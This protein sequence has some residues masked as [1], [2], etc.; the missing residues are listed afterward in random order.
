MPLDLTS[1]DC[2]LPVA[3]GV[4]INL[5]TWYVTAQPVYNALGTQNP[6]VA[7]AQAGISAILSVRDPMEVTAPTNPFDLTEAQQCILNN[8]AY[9]NV[10]LPHVPMTQAQFNVQ[11]YNAATVI[12]A[13]TAG[14]S[15]LIHCSSGDRASAAFACFLIAYDNWTNQQ[16]VEYAQDTLVLQ[17]PQFVAYVTNFQKP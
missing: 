6:Y 1:S 2:S 14:R 16:A 5:Q 7:I 9:T 13:T 11:A 15:I 17:N 12:A 4:C 8:V 10:P 3:G